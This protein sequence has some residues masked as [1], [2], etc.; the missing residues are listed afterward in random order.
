MRWL[1]RSY[2]VYSFYLAAL[3]GYDFE[4]G[5]HPA[6]RVLHAPHVPGFQPSDLHAPSCRPRLHGLRTTAKWH[7]NTMLLWLLCVVLGR[8]PSPLVDMHGCLPRAQ[9]DHPDN[10]IRTLTLHVLV[11]GN[12]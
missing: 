11:G 6:A 8:N 10:G 3:H 12:D 2:I 1:A 9:A 7:G 4:A 5:L